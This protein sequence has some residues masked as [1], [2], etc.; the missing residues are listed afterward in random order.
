ML[1]R[2]REP[3]RH[4]VVQLLGGASAAGRWLEVFNSDVYDSWVNPTVVGN[5]G[6]VEATGAPLHGFEASCA[7]VASSER[8][9][10][11]RE[12]PGD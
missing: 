7:I 2:H 3:E 8:R 5:G 4:D 11:L 10:R 9:H 6:A 12:R 1:V